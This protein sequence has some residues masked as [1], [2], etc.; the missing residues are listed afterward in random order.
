M[1]RAG[2]RPEIRTARIA[3]IGAVDALLGRSYRALL[4]ADYPPS[5]LVTV[6]PAMSRAQP[7]LL[8]SGRYFVAEDETGA[9]VGVGGWSAALPGGGRAIPGRANIR[10]VATD[11][12]ALRRGVGRA[13]LTAAMTQARAAGM[14]WCHCLS[15]RTAVPFYEAMGFEPL[16]AVNLQVRAGIDFPAV[17]MRRDL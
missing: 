8:S 13:I 12:G 4:E 7:R 16:G 2:T 17:A 15:T 9:L 5:V 10:H 6:L 1:H 11:P 3:D 14:T